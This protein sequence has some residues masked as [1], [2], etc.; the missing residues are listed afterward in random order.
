MAMLLCDVPQAAYR[1]L[2]A[3]SSS[4]C[5][6]ALRDPSEVAARRLAERA[7]TAAMRRGR[8]IHTAILE[9]DA[10]DSRYVVAPA[11]NLSTLAGADAWAEWAA[12][13]GVDVTQM[14]KAGRREGTLSALLALG[15]EAVELATLEQACALRDRVLSHAEAGPLLT[16]PGVSEG[17]CVASVPVVDGGDP[18]AKARA[19]TVE[20]KCR[21]DRVTEDGT[22]I[23]IKTSAQP[24]RFRWDM[25]DRGYDVAEA[26]CAAVLSTAG[27]RISR[28]VWIVIG[29][30][31]APR[32]VP[33]VDVLHAS[34]SGDLMRRAWGAACVGAAAWARWQA[35]PDGCAQ[36]IDAARVVTIDDWQIRGEV[37]DVE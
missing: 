18:R 4:E 11:C 28:V 5:A 7:D 36:A 12:G 21:P 26:W 6:T 25:R 32:Q 24:D 35:D 33:R 19:R 30:N 14:P 16:A 2:S 17:V 8:A 13:Y 22:L 3:L 23:Q 27:V 31:Y 1:E 9:P 37:H 20:G 10:F 15:I 29:T 34:M